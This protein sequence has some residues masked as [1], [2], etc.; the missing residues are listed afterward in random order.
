[1]SLCLCINYLNRQITR[2]GVFAPKSMISD[3]PVSYDSPSFHKSSLQVKRTADPH[4]WEC[5]FP[6]VF[7][8]NQSAMLFCYPFSSRYH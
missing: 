8:L 3:I 4:V 7:V 5:G 6:F 2:D 1:M